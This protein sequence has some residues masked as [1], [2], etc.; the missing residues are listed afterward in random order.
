MPPPIW[1]FAGLDLRAFLD[2]STAAFQDGEFPLV[3]ASGVPAVTGVTRA[4]PRGTPQ[5]RAFNGLAG[6]AAPIFWRAARFPLR[7]PIAF[8]P[9]HRTHFPNRYWGFPHFPGTV[10][11]QRLCLRGTNRSGASARHAAAPPFWRGMAG[12]EGFEPSHA[13]IKI[14]CLTAWRRPNTLNWR[15]VSLSW[16]H[17]PMCCRNGFSSRSFRVCR[18]GYSSSKS[19]VDTFGCVFRHGPGYERNIVASTI[20]W[21]IGLPGLTG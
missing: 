5:S 14:R 19:S 13:G 4:R 11:P 9:T 1:G 12:A 8:H 20:F 2:V 21:S 15:V 17:F 16:Q 7:R 18:A 6:A 3:A 10:A